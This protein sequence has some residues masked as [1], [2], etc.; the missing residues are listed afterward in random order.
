MFVF[1]RI[2]NEEDVSSN[3]NGADVIVINSYS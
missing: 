3:N 2:S 1:A